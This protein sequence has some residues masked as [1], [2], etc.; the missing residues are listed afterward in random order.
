MRVSALKRGCAIE[1][2]GG[3][4]LAKVFKLLMVGTLVGVLLWS[5]VQYGRNVP[6]EE[7]VFRYN[8]LTHRNSG[9]PGKSADY[10]YKG[11]DP[12]NLYLDLLKLSLTDTIYSDNT[13]SS[14]LKREGRI[15]PSRAITMV[16][17]KR[18]DNIQW[19]MED[20]LARGVPGDFIEAG[21]WRGGAPILM[22]AVL[23]VNHVTDRTVWVADSFEGL[24]KPNGKDF[25]ADSG[26]DLHENDILAVTQV[27]VEQN[28]RRFGLLDDRVRFVKGWFKDSLSRAPIDRLAVLRLDGDLYESTMES[29]DSLYPRLSSGGYCIIDDYYSLAACGKAV[30]DYRERSGIKEEIVRIDRY[31]AYW[32]KK[33]LP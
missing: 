10:P 5:A 29:L 9:N 33:S 22:R 20:V 7:I 25:P 14:E 6:D 18:L 2:V 30:D 32:K 3:V 31:G 16:G 12:K 15:W 23:K 27:T 11:S 28:F 26:S 21:A 13:L 1:E 4:M 24:P 8:L 19:C 17:L